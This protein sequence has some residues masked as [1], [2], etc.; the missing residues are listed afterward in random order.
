[1]TRS[2]WQPKSAPT[3]TLVHPIAHGS[4]SMGNYVGA[5]ANVGG[6]GTSTS[7]SSSS[8]SAGGGMAGVVGSMGELE[9]DETADMTALS[10]EVSPRAPTA[11]RLEGLPQLTQESR[12]VLLS[13]PVI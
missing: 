7:T 9:P 4:F 1:M 11:M 5:A 8:S 6:T 13:I 3:N 12:E 2:T 10:P